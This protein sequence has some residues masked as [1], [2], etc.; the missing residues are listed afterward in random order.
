MRRIL[1]FWSGLLL[2]VMLA[3][4][5]LAGTGRVSASF[6][7]MSLAVLGLIGVVLGHAGSRTVAKPP[8]EG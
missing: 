5:V 4:P 1:T 3:E 8:A 7:D 6:S 2:S